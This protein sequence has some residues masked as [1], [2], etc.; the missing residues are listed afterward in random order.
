MNTHRPRSNQRGFTILEVLIALVITLLGLLGIAALQS[1]LQVGELES[2]QRSQALLLLSDINDRIN[3]QR[4]TAPCFAFTTNTTTGSPYIGTAGAN[5]LAM[6]A[7]CAASTTTYNALAVTTLTYLNN[8][9]LGA[10]ESKGG[11]NVGA[12]IGA[13]ACVHYDSASALTDSGGATIPGSG[14]YT[15]AVAWQG[16]TETIDPSTS[17]ATTSWP[18]AARNCAKGLY[19]T[20]TKRRVVYLAMRLAS[21]D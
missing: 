14:I 13:R 21:L 8:L 19:G 18:T 3:T 10:A 11:A 15:I 2:Y 20:D 12:M 5:S 9:L 7:S 6:P 4:S 1:Q 17:S 16:M